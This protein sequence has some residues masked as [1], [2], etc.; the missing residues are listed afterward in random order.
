MTSVTTLMNPILGSPSGLDTSRD[1]FFYA[2][3][4]IFLVLVHREQEIEHR[5]LPSPISEEELKCESLEA[6]ERN[7]A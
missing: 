3:Q 5:E 4:F 6:A 7:K 2:V 1:K